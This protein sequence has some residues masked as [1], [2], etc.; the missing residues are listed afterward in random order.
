MSVTLFLNQNGPLALLLAMAQMLPVWDSKLFLDAQFAPTNGRILLFLNH[1]QLFAKINVSHQYGTLGPDV[2][3][4]ASSVIKPELNTKCVLTSKL[5]NHTERTFKPRADSVELLEKTLFLTP[6]V[7]QL[8][9]VPLLVFSVDKDL[10]NELL[11]LF[12]RSPDVLLKNNKSNNPESMKHVS[13]PPAQFG[14]H[15]RAKCVQ[16]VPL[17]ER[18]TELA[19]RLLEPSRANAQREI[20]QK[21]KLVCL[22][23]PLVLGPITQLAQ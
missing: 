13:F 14:D 18:S 5:R 6:L 4:I 2:L 10:D 9:N 23:S 8:T 20:L 19:R 12:L 17:R 11:L 22:R 3:P 15:S 16:C 1:A 21:S 7:L